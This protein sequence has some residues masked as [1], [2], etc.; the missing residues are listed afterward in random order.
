VCWCLQAVS[1]LA[2]RDHLPNRAALLDWA[3]SI[4]DKNDT[5]RN[6]GQAGWHWS[7]MGL[8][9][10]RRGRWNNSCCQLAASSANR[11]LSQDMVESM[12]AESLAR[13]ISPLLLQSARGD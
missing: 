12:D 7:V 2:L 11:F 3:A 4:C 9:A 8:S 10:E 6:R 13:A 5:A 1:L